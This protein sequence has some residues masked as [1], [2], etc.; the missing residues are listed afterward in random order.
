MNNRESLKEL[1]IFLLEMLKVVW[2]SVVLLGVG[3]ALPLAGI[4]WI[5]FRLFVR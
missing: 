4:A 2:V 3:V 1:I 5:L